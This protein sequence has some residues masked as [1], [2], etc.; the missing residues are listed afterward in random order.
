[1]AERQVTIVNRLGIHARAA[2]VLVDAAK[3]FASE[4][5]LEKAGRKADGKRIMTVLM[6]EAPVGSELVLRVTGSDEDEAM[7]AIA[8][9]IANRF[10][11]PD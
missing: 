5:T 2:K 6:L 4:I 3:G 11:E 1:M 8:N 9:L 10:G 7:S